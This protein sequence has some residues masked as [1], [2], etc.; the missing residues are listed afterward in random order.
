MDGMNAYVAATDPDWFHFL[1]DQRDVDEVNF[2]YPKP[3]GGRFGVLSDGQPLLFK[4]KKPY[5]HIAGGGFFK[6]YTELP[7]SLAWQTFGAKNGAATHD[8]VW[9]GITRLRGETPRPWDDPV[10]GCV[11]LVEPFFWPEDLWI[12]NPPG[13]HPNIQRGRTYDLRDGAG[14]QI[15]DAVVESL[16]HETPFLGRDAPLPV[17]LPGG[18]SEPVLQ[19][20]RLGQ[21]T[22]SALVRDVYGRRC[23]V[24]AERALPALE[25]AH[26]R[27][28]HDSE[29]HVLT[30]GI[31]LRSD[32]HRLFDA[33]YVTITP[34]HRVEASRR[35]KD[36]FDDGD[37][38]LQLHGR[39]VW[40]PSAEGQRPDAEALRWHNERVY[41]G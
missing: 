26:I 35:M 23:A 33:G 7:L 27:P 24:T 8:A 41:R 32:V 17:E 6:H 5:N 15:W 28:F 25:A 34:E 22:F 14:K 2:W 16:H 39:E 36:D 40:V 13:W 4:L 29:Q 37:N 30:N 12:P 21:G 19:R 38:Y 18:Y 10:I 9:Q 11:L 20:R 31:L 3:W 1:R